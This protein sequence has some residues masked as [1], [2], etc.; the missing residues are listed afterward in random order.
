MHI[1]TVMNVEQRETLPP[2][3]F[4]VARFSVDFS[5]VNNFPSQRSFYLELF[6]LH[7]LTFVR[8]IEW[9]RLLGASIL[10]LA[11]D[12]ERWMIPI[13]RDALNNHADAEWFIGWRAWQIEQK[14]NARSIRL[15]LQYCISNENCVARI[16]EVPLSCTT[17]TVVISAMRDRN[18]P[19]SER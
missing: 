12:I 5:L 18:Y 2:V 17:F 3:G 10:L 16:C 19:F 13:R 6:S 11:T 4:V 8:S 7:S 1:T 15:R 9:T 14:T